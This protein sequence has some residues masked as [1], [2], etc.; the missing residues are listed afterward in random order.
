MKIYYSVVEKFPTF[1]V[2]L[3]ELF[4][5]SLKRLGV[6]TIWFM[7]AYQ[8]KKNRENAQIGFEK[9]HLPFYLN[10]KGV[11]NKCF[12]KILYYISD[13]Y[14]LTCLIFRHVDA[15]Q[16]RDK[17][18]AAIYG[19]LIAKIKNIPFFYWCSYPYP[20]HDLEMAKQTKGL[21]S[22][23]YL[24][25]GAFGYYA[26]YKF[27]MK[28]ANH[29]FVQSERMQD[30]ISAYGVRIDSMTAVPM[31]VSHTIFEKIADL[32]KESSSENEFVYLGTLAA[33]RK[34]NV[35][36]TA[37]SKVIE[38]HKDARLIIVGEGDYPEEKLNL[39]QLA[40]HLGIIH[41]VVFTGFIPMEKAWQIVSKSFACISPFYPTKA[42]ISASPTKLVEYLALG[43]PVIVNNH[44]DQDNVIRSSEAGLSVD[45]GCEQFADA[46]IWM[47]ENPQAAK[48]MGEKGPDW[49]RKHR[50]YDIIAQQVYSKYIEIIGAVA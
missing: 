20:E 32:N 27:V 48:A 5:V 40:E 42:L 11:F 34:L 19:L 3:T 44:P 43:K 25:R 14:C 31:A 17:Y 18:I 29:S 46:M 10:G 7:G 26:L 12:N 9:V 21:N 28:L 49:V 39:I 15:V 47:L 37:F 38:K 4:G 8:S 45:W 33:V 1:R 13:V 36:I 6:E 16:V 35:I 23:I 41:N 24:M 2:D 22:I 50:V 30:D